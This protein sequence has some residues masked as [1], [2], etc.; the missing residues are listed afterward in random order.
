MY[1]TISNREKSRNHLEIPPQGDKKS[2]KSASQNPSI[3]NKSNLSL[4]NVSQGENQSQVT[5]TQALN[6][7]FSE[8]D[9]IS[10]KSQIDSRISAEIQRSQVKS[11]S[12]FLSGGNTKDDQ[13]LKNLT[14]S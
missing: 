1:E 14:I 10:L 6:Q 2:Q 4:I 11:E 5:E 12:S 13:E 3:E 9:Q 8:Q 7:N